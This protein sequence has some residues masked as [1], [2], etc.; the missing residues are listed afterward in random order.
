MRQRPAYQLL[1]LS[2]LKFKSLRPK[3]LW[4]WRGRSWAPTQAPL[5]T[6]PDCQQ[7]VP[8]W[9][10]AFKT[11]AVYPKSY[12][13][14]VSLQTSFKSAS[15]G[16]LLP[17][18]HRGEKSSK[19]GSGFYLN[20]PTHRWPPRQQ[21][22]DSLKRKGNTRQELTPLFLLL[23]CLVRCHVNVELTLFWFAA[24]ATKLNNYDQDSD[25][26]PAAKMNKFRK[27]H[28]MCTSSTT[29]KHD[30]QSFIR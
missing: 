25:F 1:S 24:A 15:C 30:H 3:R 20:E 2:P 22:I 27:V 18:T 11:F 7:S 21:T 26:Q 8:G 16:N 28:L 19:L 17:Q 6:Q 29:V 5:K 10:R 13:F 23:L 14:D 12:V 4:S 9:G